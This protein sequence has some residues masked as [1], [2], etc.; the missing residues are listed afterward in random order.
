H[1]EGPES[2]IQGRESYPVV[3]VAYSDATA[4]AKWAGK[5]LPTEAEWEFAARGGLTG[6]LYAWGNEF[7]P[8]GKW[9]A[10]TFQ[11]RFPM[12]DTGEINTSSNHAGFRCARDATATRAQETN[13]PSPTMR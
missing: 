1:P 7:R 3:H 8:A 2:N 5:R 13:A 6:K 9:M 4:F 10:N 12:K 11:G